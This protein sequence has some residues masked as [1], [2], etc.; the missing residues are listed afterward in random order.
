MEFVSPLVWFKA[1]EEAARG[2]NWCEGRRLFSV[3]HTCI[4]WM[5]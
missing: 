3:T 1:K 2:R 5:Y 4:D